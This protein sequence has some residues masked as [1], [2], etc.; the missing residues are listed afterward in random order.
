[1][2]GRVTA[3]E[4]YQHAFMRWIEMLDQDNRQATIGRHRAE[5]GTASVETASGSAE[6]DDRI[7]VLASWR[8]ALWPQAADRGWHDIARL[9]LLRLGQAFLFRDVYALLRNASQS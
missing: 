8:T 7:V 5:N 2:Q 3:E 9:R 4:V 1:M 6:A